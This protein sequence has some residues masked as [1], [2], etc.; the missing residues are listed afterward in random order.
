MATTHSLE[1]TAPG[2]AKRRFDFRSF[3]ANYSTI[4]IFVVLVLVASFISTSFLSS[5]NIENVL[6]QVAGTGVIS[7]GM[8]LVILTG[9]IDLSVGSVAALGSIVC[10]SLLTS[11]SLWTAV[12]ISL[13]AGGAL[14]TISGY[15]VAVR[16]MP[17]FVVTL[18]GMT[19]ARGL[20]LIVSEGRPIFMADNGAWLG[21]GFNRGSLLGIPLPVVLMLLVFGATAFVLRLTAYGRLIVAIG[22]NSEAVRLS[23]V[24]VTPRIFSVYVVSGVLSALAGIIITA[25]S[26]V[27][28]PVVGI[29]MELDVI[30]AVV[31]G[32]ASL[33]GGRGTA[34]NTL[35]GVLT[36]GVIGNIMN[37]LNVPG[38]HQEVV[39]GVII[40][41]AVLL[42]SSVWPRR[43]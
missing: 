12:P 19:I 41:V 28:S 16:R 15:F 29:G 25:R 37:L 9:G 7:M 27:G 2:T 40:L 11:M 20:A 33:M 35:I 32:G 36:L 23:G 26:G 5:R 31:I 24:R 30:A 14:G 8:L 1:A 10:A 4:A 13:A 6:R 38:Y 3:A 21:D 43:A 42:Q 17:S 18:A 34:L 22:S 39:K